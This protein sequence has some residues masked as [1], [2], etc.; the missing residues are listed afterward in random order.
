MRPRA[1]ARSAR[2]CA[3][4][5]PLLPGERP[6]SA[7][8]STTG[9]SGSSRSSRPSIRSSRCPIRRPGASAR[10]PPRA[11][12]RCATACRCSRS[13]TRW[14]R[15]RCAP[16]WSASRGSSIA[17]RRSRFVAEPKLDGAGVELVYEDGALAVGSTRGD[18]QRRRGRDREPAPV[19]ARAPRARGAPPGARL[20][21]RRG[22]AAAARLP[23]AERAAQARGLEP[24]ANPRN[25][26]AGALRQLHEVDLERLRSLDFR[27]YALGE[28]L[29]DGVRLA[30][31]GA[32]AARALG[33]RGEPGAAP[34][35]SASTRR[36]PTTASCSSGARAS[37]SRST[38]SCSRWTSSRSSAISASSRACRA[39]R[40][41]TSS[42]RI[43]RHRRRGHRHQRRTH[44]SA[45]AGREARPVQVGG[46][47]V[48]NASLHNQDEIDRK[49]VRIGDTRDRQRAGD[50]IPQIVGVVK[51]AAAR[52]RAEP[53]GCRALPGVRHAGRARGR[54]R[55]ARAARTAPARRSSRTACC[56]SR[57]AA[58]STSTAW[59]RS[60]WI[61]CSR[62]GS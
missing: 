9:A 30:V 15:R 61:S 36:S 50:V 37:R 18:G 41:P 55:G 42:R 21:A 12:R 49:D 35:A 17:A 48:S 52:R 39:G 34:S 56:T 43:R 62:A 23:A 3:S 19:L 51:S 28:G 11:S 16:C 7:T 13:T 8:P 26:A 45:H 22:G 47:T 54:R 6:S 4:R 60:S 14:T 44:G 31:G 58:R 46:V 32:R 33:L 53:G 5:A 40:S 38:A 27:A 29:P 10:R 59:A 1:S 25:A 57:A 20:G 2:T 24:F